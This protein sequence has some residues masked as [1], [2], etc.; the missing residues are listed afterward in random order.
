MSDQFNSGFIFTKEIFK[1]L[2]HNK[3]KKKKNIPNDNKHFKSRAIQSDPVINIET[4]R[5]AKKW[6]KKFSHNQP[7]H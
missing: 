7:N 2:I 5:R 6:V 3:S 1:I 4:D